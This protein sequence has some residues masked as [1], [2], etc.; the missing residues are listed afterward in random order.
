MV[1]LCV[2]LATIIAIFVSRKYFIQ[3]TQNTT[4]S[5]PIDNNIVTD[6]EIQDNP[7]Y[8]GDKRTYSC[9]SDN[10]YYYI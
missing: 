3:R 4:I 10:D 9:T 1:P 8:H 6:V 2:I 5:A 7:A